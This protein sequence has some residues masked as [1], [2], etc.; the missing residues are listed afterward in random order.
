MQSQSIINYIRTIYKQPEGQ[1]QLHEPRFN[2]NEKKYVLETI[3]STFV[4]FTGKFA[5][6]FEE[7]MAEFTGSIIGAGSVV[8]KDITEPG[9]YISSALHKLR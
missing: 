7:I 3:D 6:R 1:K 9:I 5:V 8:Y 4:S 2:G